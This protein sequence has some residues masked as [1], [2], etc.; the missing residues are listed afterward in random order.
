MNALRLSDESN[1]SFDEALRE[2][3]SA[4][5]ATDGEIDAVAALDMTAA[6]EQTELDS[7]E[8]LS[9]FELITDDLACTKVRICLNQADTGLT[10][11]FPN[12]P[13]LR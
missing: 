5:G 4:E 1:E 2:S 12:R 13:R 7:E 6:V 8:R 3:M 10:V 9:Q 11:E